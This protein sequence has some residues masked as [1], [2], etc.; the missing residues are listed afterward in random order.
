MEPSQRARISR[1][2]FVRRAAM[3]AVAA[4]SAGRVGGGIARVARASVADAGGIPTLAVEQPVAGVT[5][6]DGR[7]VA[8]GGYPGDP[9]VWTHSIGAAGW[10][11]DAS[12]SAFPSVTG[13]RA[14]SSSAQDLIAAGWA[15]GRS[16]YEPAI[17]RSPDGG[18]WSQV[19]TG[20]GSMPG[21]F[22]AVTETDGRVLAVG[23]RFAEP[24]IGEPVAPIAAVA[25]GASWAPIELEGFGP[26]PHGAVTLLASTPD[27]LM[28]AVTDV[29]GVSLYRSS[30]IRSTWLH[31]G[32]PRLDGGGALVAA[33]TVGDRVVLAG[34]DALD[35][36]R[37]W[38]ETPGGWR[39]VRTS[40]P[41]PAT[42]RVMGLTHQA[43]S[44]V[45]VEAGDDASFVGEVTFG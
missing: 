22:T 15:S 23:A 39:E 3:G 40:G 41:L 35:R 12:G 25:E 4:A 24:E 37:F 33:A 36:S 43:S 11:L 9:R 18:R 5:A 1:R 44:L 10:Q 2:E 21:V 38:L 32:A 34:I 13:L 28:L 7:L 16:G 42:A 6:Q 45:A 27:G 17:F 29:T 14:V 19:D 30:G 31:V 20:L 8:V 26:T